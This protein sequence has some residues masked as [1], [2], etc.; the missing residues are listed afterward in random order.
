MSQ[1]PELHQGCVEF[2]APAEYM[3]RPPQAPVYMFVLDV[4]PQAQANGSVQAAVDA[5]RA[6][7]D[8]EGGAATDG[9]GGHGLP[10]GS[11]TQ[12]GFLTY[13]SSLHFYN[14]KSALSQPQMLVVADLSDLFLPAPDDLLVNLQESRHVVD[15]LLDALPTMFGAHAP[16]GQQNGGAQGGG[17]AAQQQAQAAA[18]SALGPALSAAYHV[19]A[20]IGGKMC[21]FQSNLP[22]LGA[23]RLQHREVKGVAGTDKEHTLLAPQISWYKDQAVEFSKRQICVEQ[24]L[25]AAQY[26]DVA[27]LGGLA[28]YTGGQVH[29][30]PNFQAAVDGPLFAAELR[31][32]LTRETGWEAVMRVRA[33]R[34]VKVTKFYGNFFIRGQDLLALPNADADATFA[35]EL[36]HEQNMI[37]TNQVSVQSALLYTTSNGERRIRVTTVV[38]PVTTDGADICKA[39]DVE[40]LCNLEAKMA[41]DVA[42]TGGLNAARHKLQQ[43]CVGVIRSHRHATSA[44]PYGGMGGMPQAQQGQQLSLPESL[45]LL[46]LYTMSL[47]KNPAFRGGAEVRADERAA[48]L[49]ALARMPTET[50]KL[51][52]YPRMFELHTLAADAGRLK[53]LPPQGIKRDADG[54]AEDESIVLLR[55][56]SSMGDLGADAAAPNGDANPLQQLQLPPLV[57]LSAE[58]LAS[59]GAFLLD[60]GTALTLWLGRAVAPGLTQA[61]F[62]VGSLDQVDP[63]T[64]RLRRLNNDVSERVNNI[65]AALRP[66]GPKGVAHAQLRVV[67]EGDPRTEARFYWNLVEDRANFAGGSFAYPEYLNHVNRLSYQSAGPTAPGGR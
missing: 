11:R 60:S 29:Y 34:G 9:E 38:A 20:H 67:R 35:V 3:V 36:A 51:V 14:L 45:Q 66:L 10:G 62:G 39:V 64:L 30:F 59:D 58:R 12:V 47:Q 19:M 23:G 44:G 28:K 57:N 21:V 56:H 37:T 18:G 15:A 43:H 1:R 5:I 13:D 8:G 6:C 46:P 2:V 49:Y 33:T 24:F 17:G 48:L 26:T 27:T 53:N 42:V 40:A 55:R 4:S 31:R 32:S 65:V 22:S 54:N 50:S 61:L 7:L 16:G 41:A 63:S 25:F 52:M